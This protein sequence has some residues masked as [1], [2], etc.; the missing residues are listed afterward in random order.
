M[1]ETGDSVDSLN[2]SRVFALLD[3][4]VSSWGTVERNIV[5]DGPPPVLEESSGARH[6]IETPKRPVLAADSCRWARSR[7]SGCDSSVRKFR[8][9][10]TVPARCAQ[11]IVRRSMQVGQHC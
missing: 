11:E 5:H 10:E 9:A 6:D 4:R 3:S 7:S 1:I 2:N 8:L